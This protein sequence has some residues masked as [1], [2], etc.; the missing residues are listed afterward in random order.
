[1]LVLHVCDVC[2]YSWRLPTLFYPSNHPAVTAFYYDHGIEFD[3]AQYEQRTLLLD[4]EEELLSDDPIRIRI[5]IPLD[6]EE[7]LLTFDEEMNVDDVTRRSRS[8]S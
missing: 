1:M 5:T 2:T 7:L 4:Y 3:L 6:D 8:P